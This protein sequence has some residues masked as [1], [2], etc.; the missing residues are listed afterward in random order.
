VLSELLEK[1]KRGH[2]PNQATV[3][4][5]VRRPEQAQRLAE[6][7]VPGILFEDLDDVSVIRDAAMNHDSKSKA[8]TD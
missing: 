7:G 3:S 1:I 4:A 8:R 5:L 2:L 6:A